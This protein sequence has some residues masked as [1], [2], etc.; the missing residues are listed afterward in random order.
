MS[1]NNNT[2]RD[3]G[4][5]SEIIET[6]IKL[7]N[8]SDN[9]CCNNSGCDKPF[10][11]PSPS[12]ICFN[13][14]PLNFYSCCDGTLWTFPYTLDGVTGTSSVFR[15]EDIDGC[16]VTCRILA[17]NPDTTISPYI[18]TNSF[19][20]IV[21]FLIFSIKFINAVYVPLI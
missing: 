5:F 19:F 11:G 20:T 15:V 16:C 21:L 17:P 18:A 7:Q 13:T 6:I 8:F 3:C 12:V 2:N 4:C 1:C 14:R 10:L 9:D